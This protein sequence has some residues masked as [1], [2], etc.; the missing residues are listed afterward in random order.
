VALLAD[1]QRES[2]DHVA[3]SLRWATKLTPSLFS[4]V[5][6]DVCTRF[7]APAQARQTER[8]AHLVLAE[9][10]T[11]AALFLIEGELPMRRLRRLIYDGGEW[12]CSLSRHPGVPIEIDDAADGRHGT[13]PIAILLSFVEAKRLMTTTERARVVSML[14]IKPAIVHRICCDNF[15]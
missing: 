2:W 4:K 15:G 10:W 5:I 8:L 9:A 14:R 1:E 13:R 3:H 11:D 6:T 12:M 7:P